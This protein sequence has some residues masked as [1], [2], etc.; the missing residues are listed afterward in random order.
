MTRSALLA[1]PRILAITAG[2][3][4]ALSVVQAFLVVGNDPAY[5]SRL[6]FGIAALVLGLACSVAGWLSPRGPR[7][8]ALAL[9]LCSLAG[10][11]A[12]SLYYIDTAYYLVHSMGRGGGSDFAE[13]DRR[14]ARNFAEAARA[15]GVQRIIY[16]GGLGEPTSA[17]LRSRH[18]TAARLASTEIPLTYFRAAIVI[19]QGSE[20]LRTIAPAFAAA[21]G[22]W[23]PD[24]M[25]L[26]AE[27]PHDLVAVP[28]SGDGAARTV[29]AL[30][31][32]AGDIAY[33]WPQFFPDG[34]HVVLR[35]YG[36]A[37]VY[38]YPGFK[39]VGAFELPAQEQG[40]GIAVG[41]DGRLY[42]S[43]EEVPSPILAMDVPAKVA[44]AMERGAQPTAGA[45]DEKS[46]APARDEAGKDGADEQDGPGP[47]RLADYALA[48]VLGAAGVALLV[49]ASRRRSRRTR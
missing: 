47:G 38:T 44:A 14:G 43:S 10:A 18:E 9:A 13:R 40:E 26:I 33:A 8:A 2:L 42:L 4:A 39:M 12:I 11:A 20:S 19:G 7:R 48:A 16:L 24:G 41:K 21:G 23:G 28:A 22:A 17:H 36:D 35:T 30:D 49:R 1:F 3:L 37:A 25:I 27:L 34:R 31:R 6:P 45:Q 15:G 29:A 32:D 5:Q 46:P